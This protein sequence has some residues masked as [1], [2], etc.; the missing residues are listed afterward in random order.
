MRTLCAWP[1]TGMKL[2]NRFLE[3][4]IERGSQTG[5]KLVIFGVHFGIVRREKCSL[6]CV[7]LHFCKLV[8][9]SKVPLQIDSW[10]T[11]WFCPV[12]RDSL[13]CRAYH[14]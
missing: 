9:Q 10:A 14:S 11:P 13:P 5:D 3:L 4:L 6:E 2:S 8:E 1:I 12:L 7:A